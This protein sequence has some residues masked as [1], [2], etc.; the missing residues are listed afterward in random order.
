M[1]ERGRMQGTPGAACH[2][3][4]SQ[5]WK[6]WWVEIVA[7]LLCLNSKGNGRKT[8]FHRFER[9]IHR[10]GGVGIFLNRKWGQYSRK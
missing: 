1:R 3:S 8:V 4:L 9:K 7:A 5:W 2:P 10:F 6:M